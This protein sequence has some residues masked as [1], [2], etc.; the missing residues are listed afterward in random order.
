MVPIPGG[1]SRVGSPTSEWG[2]E[3]RE[4]ERI[5]QVAAFEMARTEVSQGLFAQYKEGVFAEFAEVGGVKVDLRG[6]S[7]PAQHMN[8][9][10]A[11]G[12]AN[13]M[14]LRWNEAHPAERRTLA[15]TGVDTEEEL[16]R[17]IFDQN[18]GREVSGATGFRLPTADEWEHA[19]RAGVQTSSRGVSVP[20]VGSADLEQVCVY[21]N[22]MLGTVASRRVRYD[23]F[24]N[25][26]FPC[27]DGHLVP[28]P[29]A[30]FRPNLWG[31]YD[32]TGNVAELT[33]SYL[34]AQ[35][36]Q[37]EVAADDYEYTVF[38]GGSWQS[39]VD[40]ARVAQWDADFFRDF[41]RE[42]LGLRLARSLP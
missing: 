35:G 38:R 29:V 8:W 11:A 37:P 13:W 12:F 42:S 17:C 26:G 4:T 7:R 10:E 2:R 15:Y 41:R 31:L 16:R 19:A 3:T 32:M 39:G 34:S 1:W 14:T 40:D 30:S 22:V 25:D 24:W 9:C 36:E 33:Q 23:P 20:Y 27:Q 18:T 5:I 6:Y 28:A 21:A